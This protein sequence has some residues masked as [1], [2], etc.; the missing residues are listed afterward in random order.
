MGRPFPFSYRAARDVRTIYD[1][2][3]GGAEVPGL[4]DYLKHDA[5][6]DAYRQAVGVQICQR[7]LDRRGLLV[8]SEWESPE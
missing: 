5:L 3:Y 7:E 6:A 8:T 2:A 1:L 4:P